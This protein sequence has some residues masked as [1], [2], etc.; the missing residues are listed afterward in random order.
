MNNLVQF[1]NEMIQQFSAQGK[2]VLTGRGSGMNGL[3]I[4]GLAPSKDDFAAE[5]FFSGAPGALLEK[6]LASVDLSLDEC[7]ATYI[8]PYLPQNSSIPTPIDM[9]HCFSWLEGQLALLKPKMLLTLGDQ[10]TRMF[11]FQS[12]SLEGM[13]G[14]FYPWNGTQVRPIF[15]LQTLLTNDSK[16]KDG[17]K[18][19][20]WQDLIE[21]KQTLERVQ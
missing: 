12:I 1:N 7:Y 6:M 9:I 2:D 17:P 5:K 8:V 21:V 11:L 14:K 15:D 20:T 18:Y 3:A 4:I 19:L 16:Q 13:R 10:V